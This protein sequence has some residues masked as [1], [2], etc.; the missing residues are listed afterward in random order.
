MLEAGGDQYDDFEKRRLR[1]F[2][3]NVF[4]TMCI[5]G[6]AAFEA[7]RAVVTTQK[8]E[9]NLRFFIFLLGMALVVSSWVVFIAAFVILPDAWW[10]WIP[11]IISTAIY[12]FAFMNT[13]RYITYETTP[14]SFGLPTVNQP[15]TSS[16]WLYLWIAGINMIPM[17]ISFIVVTTDVYNEVAVSLSYASF[18]QTMMIFCANVMIFL[19]HKCFTTPTSV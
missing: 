3:F 19:P 6:T 2:F 10:L 11:G 18:V 16:E 4:N 14:M 13:V 8:G 9:K 5:C 17:A 12:F 1:G 15:T 7:F